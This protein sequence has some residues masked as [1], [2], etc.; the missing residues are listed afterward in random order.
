MGQFV[1][2]TV[3]T[4][5]IWN[6]GP[7]YVRIVKQVADGTYKSEAF[8]GHLKDGTFD[9]A[10][11]SPLVPDDVKQMVRARKQELIDGKFAVFCG[12]LKTADGTEVLAEGKCMNLGEKLSMDFFIEGVKGDIDP[13]KLLEQ[14]L[15]GEPA[16]FELSGEGATEASTAKPGVAFVYVGPVGDLGWSFTHDQGRLKMAEQLGVRTAIAGSVPEGPDA[17]A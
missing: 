1:G 7:K 14:P 9:L 10:P 3:L 13:S 11:F 5:P 4:S 6:W 17:E 12:P 16:P 2:E 8:Y 15:E